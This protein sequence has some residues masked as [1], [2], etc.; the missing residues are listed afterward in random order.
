MLQPGF[1]V[2]QRP[3][4]VKAIGVVPIPS[5]WVGIATSP[6]VLERLSPMPENS[7]QDQVDY[8]FFDGTC[9]LCHGTVRFLA[10]R[11]NRARFRFAPLQGETFVHRVS[12]EK[13]TGLP[14]SVVVETAEGELLVRSDGALRLLR[15]AGGGWRLVAAGL[16]LVPRRLRDAAY[17]MV[18]RGRRRWFG[19]PEEICPVMEEEEA[20]LFLP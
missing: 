20:R 12:E 13:R 14:D 9:G 4:H 7:H 11:R 6:K 18:A 1:M 19:R 10:R 16:S 17:D 3:N 2:I 15:R 8:V 5:Q